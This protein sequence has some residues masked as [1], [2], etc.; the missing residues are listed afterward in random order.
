[1]SDEMNSLYKRGFGFAIELAANYAKPAS[2]QMA[3]F[4]VCALDELRDGLG[5]T[6]KVLALGDGLDMTRCDWRVLVSMCITC[7]MINPIF[8]ELRNLI[9]RLNCPRVVIH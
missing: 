2:L 7:I 1:M 4:I 9:S 6:P 5:R 3:A 8:Q